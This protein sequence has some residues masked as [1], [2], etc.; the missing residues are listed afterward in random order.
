MDIIK[1]NLFYQNSLY[2]IQPILH[3]MQHILWIFLMIKASKKEQKMQE[4]GMT[5]NINK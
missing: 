3:R 5:E 4:T 2:G 1:I